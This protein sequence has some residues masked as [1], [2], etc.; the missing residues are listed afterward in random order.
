MNRQKA[1]RELGGNKRLVQDRV[2]SGWDEETAAKT[3]VMSLSAA[4][5]RGAKK[6]P[7]RSMKIGKGR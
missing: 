2:E 1:S 4:G 3:P 5:S 6:S 7:W